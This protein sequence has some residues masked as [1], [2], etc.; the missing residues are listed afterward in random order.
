MNKSRKAF[1]TCAI[2]AALLGQNFLFSQNVLAAS[3]SM[4]PNVNSSAYNSNNIFTQCGFKGQCTWFTYGR[5]LEKLNMKL[6]SQF[7]GNAI[8]WWY[9][10]IR[11]NTFSYGSEPQANSIVVWSGGSKGYGHVGFVEKVV[12]DTIYYNEGNVERRG[13]YDGYVKTIS[14]QAIKNRG[15]L[16]LKGYI[17]LNGSS[18]SS[19][20]NSNNDYTI[21]KTSKVSCSSLNVRSNPSLSS[22]VIGGVSKNQTVS[23]ISESNGWSKIKYG[24]GIG[25]VS[26][27]YLYAGN[28][29]I[30]SGNGGSSSNESVQPGFVKLS[31]SS[32]LLN[33]RSSANLSSSIIGSLKNGSS[34]S[35]L[36]KTGSWYKIKYGSKVAYVSSNYISS[37]NNSNSNSDNNS[38]TSTGKGTVKLSSTSSS[39]NL[40]DN[41]SLSSKILGGLSHGSSVDI[42]GKTGSWY[43]IK[44]GSK[45]GYVSSQF[46]TTSNSSN[47]SGSSV[48]N[49]KFGTV[50]LSN[51]YST[52][53][54][55]KNA[56]TNSSV[57]SSLAYGSKVE[58]LS[59]SGEW[60]KI[61]FK[62]TTGYVYSKYIKDTAQKVV[63]FN[64]SATQDKKYGVKEDNVTINNK[65]ADVAKSN[66]ENEKKLV[67]M[68]SEKE[69]EQ[70]RKKSSEPVQIKVTEEAQRKATEEAQR[71][72]AEEAQ[73]KAT[74]EAQRKAAEEAQR[75]A[76][77][78]AQRKAAEEAQRKATEEAQ[79]KEAEVEASESQSKGQSNVSE[80]APAT[81][82]DVT[83][84]ARQY[85]GTP[86]VWGG[87]S[88]SGF[89]CSG[90]VQYVYRNAAGISLPR[91]TYGQIG[92]G[93]RV[94]QD[95]LQPGDLVFPDAGHVGIY[96]GGGQ[97]IHASKPGDVVKISSVWAFYAGVR[98]K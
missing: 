9:S 90:F 61:N 53:N 91:D 54:V 77:E 34:V 18:N 12:G 36:G 68:K 7:Y 1:T 96:I 38:S 17:Y 76:T 55:R 6:P 92:A 63:A 64:Q 95:Q 44:Y 8:D 26:S 66:T 48:T 4:Y 83:S 50:Y 97:M 27:Q 37:S 65:S 51:K 24:S 40:R 80:K 60:Y 45:I 67:T 5:A 56:G 32:S 52:L 78:E 23:I 29:T 22:A 39:L 75:K 13:Y 47:S 19:N 25:Y 21:I 35:I 57:I 30:N 16:F 42:L 86:Y 84:Y 58:I 20:N 10:N 73:R 2:S 69:K 89:D 46:I 82:G 71:K 87:T 3:D 31:N 59:S 49:Q 85:L 88:P 94:S 14:K 74:E 43:K 93:S 70:E 81:H 28:N 15:N 72:A 98:I 11:S 33:V 62:N 79:R 41:P